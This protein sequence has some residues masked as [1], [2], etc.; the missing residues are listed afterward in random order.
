MVKNLD[1]DNLVLQ[2]EQGIT[3]ILERSGE[4]ISTNM[5]Q[6][7]NIIV[8]VIHYKIELYVQ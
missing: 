1:I 3:E 8:G 4:I 2:M 6:V 7:N 5:F